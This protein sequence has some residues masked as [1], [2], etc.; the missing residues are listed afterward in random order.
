MGSGAPS[1]AFRA[2]AAR[3]PS[4]CA[5]RRHRR[6]LHR[7]DL[8]GCSEPA[9]LPPPTHSDPSEALWLH[10]LPIPQ[11]LH[12]TSVLIPF[13][14][15]SLVPRYPGPPWRAFLPPS[16]V[17]HP[18]PVGQ[19]SLLISTPDLRL[20]DPSPSSLGCCEPVRFI[21]ASS[22]LA[23]RRGPAFAQL[24]SPVLFTSCRPPRV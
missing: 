17:F 3:P 23:T 12:V 19:C 9:S 2:A 13:L 15:A 1:A 14:S 11:E 24:L 5:L 18:C 6:G 8:R 22:I 7:G 10:F 20:P 16:T 21:P 4:A